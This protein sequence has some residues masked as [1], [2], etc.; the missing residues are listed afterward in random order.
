M[1]TTDQPATTTFDGSQQPGP[2]QGPGSPDTDDTGTFK[3]HGLTG[4][5]AL[6]AIGEQIAERDAEE[7]TTIPIQ[8]P[9][10]NVRMICSTMVP[11]EE[12]QK[13]QL[14]ALPA[15]ERKSRRPKVVLTSQLVLSCMVL[16]GTCEAI[17][18]QVDGEWQPMKGT[19]GEVY[20]L[21][22]EEL[23]RRFAVVDT[24]VFL[25]KLFGRDPRLLAAAEKVIIASEWL[26]DEDDLD[27][28]A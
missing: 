7:E 21:E 1:T 28:T 17:E 11:Y 19:D 16:I 18:H 15:K 9:G 6:D 2:H 25:R 4:F 22:S 20:T 5:S 24:N 26:E 27:P 10:L 3:A 12:Y 23:L 13:W 8:V 14:A